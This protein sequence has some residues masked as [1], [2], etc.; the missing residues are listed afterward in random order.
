MAKSLIKLTPTKKKSLLL[1]SP[2]SPSSLSP[3]PN[4]TPDDTDCDGI[5]RV[6]AYA[7]RHD[8]VLCHLHTH[9]RAFHLLQ[10]SYIEEGA[11]TYD[12]TRTKTERVS[13][14]WRGHISE[15]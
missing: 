15:A 4:V 5:V 8:G 13:D 14:R 3:P 9:N 1:S 12:T 2:T 11:V 7:F 10:T 6:A